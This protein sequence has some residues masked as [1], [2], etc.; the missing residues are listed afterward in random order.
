MGSNEKSNARSNGNGRKSGK[1]GSD[2][3]RRQVDRRQRFNLCDRLTGGRWL[4]WAQF[5]VSHFANKTNDD[6]TQERFRADRDYRK[7]ALFPSPLWAGESHTE[8]VGA[9][10]LLRTGRSKTRKRRVSILMW[11]RSD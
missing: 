8:N 3:S 1:S 2:P 11:S 4:R 7:H 5:A 9:S 10:E 6:A